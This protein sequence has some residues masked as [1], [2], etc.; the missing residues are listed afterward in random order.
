MR[1]RALLVLLVCL[2]L[3]GNTLGVYTAL[4][5]RRELHVWDFQ[6]LWQAGRWVLEGQGDPY[7][8]EMTHFLQMQ[9]YGRLAEEGEDPRAFVYPL[10]VLLLLAPLI[11]LPLPWAQAA[12]F[13]VLELGL[14]IGVTGA[15]RLTGWRPSARRTLLT[16]M[17][18]FLLYPVAWALLLGQV[19]ILIFALI[20]A[21]LL[22]MRAGQEGWAGICLALTTA[23]P[24]MTFLLVPAVLLWALVQCHYRLLLSFAS[25]MGVLLLISFAVLPG[26]LL[27]TL[28]AGAGYFQA[29]PFPPPVALLGEAVGGEWGGAVTLALGALLLAGLAWAWWRERAGEPL[30]VWAIGLTLVVTTLIAPRTSMVNQVPLLLPLCLLFADLARRFRRERLLTVAVQVALLLGLWSIDLLWFPPWNSGEH[31]H[32]QQRYI[33][34]IL[35]TLLLVGL[36]MRPWWMRRGARGP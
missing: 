15:I 14:F 13:T 1:E 3:T 5:S 20:I 34:P 19:S 26:W 10:Y 31:W 17:W 24:Q 2:F 30:P 32:A 6:P 23:K 12:W 16:V 22:A 35:P 4:T 11:L 18:G 33:A 25:A 36:T 8:R 21:A 27:G 28:R 29:Q 9:S 7:S